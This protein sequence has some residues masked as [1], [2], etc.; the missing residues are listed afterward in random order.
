MAQDTKTYKDLDLNFNI[1]P[2]KKDINK[3]TGDMSV[4]GSFKNLIST[5][6]YERPF[7]PDIGSNVRHL[8][9]EPAD[10]IT[11]ASLEREIR[12]T[13]NNWD[14]RITIKSAN[15]IPKP[16]ENGY[17]IRLEFYITNRTE[18]VNISFLLERIR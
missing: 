10:A 6:H 5:N 4:I 8:L 18:P 12:E 11:A 14:P 15:V 1:H 16:D 13:I 7:Q 17:Q 2:I 9:F 3:L